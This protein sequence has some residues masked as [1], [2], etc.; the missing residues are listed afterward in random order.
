M[1][2]GYTD[3]NSTLSQAEVHLLKSEYVEARR[4]HRETTENTSLDQGGEVYGSA[5]LNIAEINVKIDAP[6]DSVYQTLE[7]AKTIF[8]SFKN[9]RGV[10]QCIM[11]GAD[12]NL[13]EKN[14][15][16][17]SILLRDCLR[18]SWSRGCAT[19]SYCLDRL[20]DFR[21]W[22]ETEIHQVSVWPVV[23]LAFA[24]KSN[25]KLALHRALLFLGDLYLSKK[26]EDTA[27]SL[28]TVALEGFTHMD[29]HHSR[30]QCMLRLGD[31]ANT[32][33]E[34]SKALEHW[35]AARPLF[36]RCLQ[37]K[38]VAHIDD[39]LAQEALLLLLPKVCISQEQHWE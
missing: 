7:K 21:Q 23:Y 19:V 12:L 29:V 9:L 28:F 20:A 34:T 10:I 22:D 26:D 35:K 17:A 13:R 5:L 1:S 36:E 3:I 32:R 27:E 24:K 30:A 25:Q 8:S 18:S 2:G 4:I 11:I 38:D 31:V 39:R 33:G 16:S 37:T 14:T 6:E 15:R